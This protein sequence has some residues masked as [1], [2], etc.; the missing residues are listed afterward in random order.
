MSEL[1][2][3]PA[4]R[5]RSL[6]RYSLSSVFV[7]I[8]LVAL[9]ANW[10]R[11]A[12]RQRK[13]VNELESRKISVTYDFQISPQKRNPSTATWFHYTSEEAPKTSMRHWLSLIH[14]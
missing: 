6:L 9:A 4:L 13:I 10:W 1:N 5:L 7:L 14:I 11:L 3:K 8:V 2:S 12:D